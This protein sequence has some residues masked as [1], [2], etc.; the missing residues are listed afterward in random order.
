F[1]PQMQMETLLIHYLYEMKYS[2]IAKLTGVSVSTVK[3]R[4]KQGTEKLREV[5][6]R[7]DFRD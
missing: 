6:K 3:S 5:M 1:L 2:E 4:V 7:E